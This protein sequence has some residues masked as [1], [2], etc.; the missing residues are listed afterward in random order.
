M[1]GLVFRLVMDWMLFSG[2]CACLLGLLIGR[3]QIRYR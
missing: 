2:G 1:L 3:D